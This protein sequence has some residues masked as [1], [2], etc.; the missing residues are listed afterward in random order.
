[1]SPPTYDLGISEAAA[2]VGVH[3]DTLRA[4]ADDGKVPCWV[5]PSGH[6]RFRMSDLEALLPEDAA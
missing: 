6:R 1:M 2:V 5:T 3:P 4:W